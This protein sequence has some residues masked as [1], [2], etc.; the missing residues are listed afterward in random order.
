MNIM[1]QVFL[2]SPGCGAPPTA[3]AMMF[4]QLLGAKRARADSTDTVRKVFGRKGR[5]QNTFLE[6][7]DSQL[8]SQSPRNGPMRCNSAPDMEHLELSLHGQHPPDLEDED[9]TDC[10]EH[11]KDGEPRPSAASTAAPFGP[12]SAASESAPLTPVIAPDAPEEDGGGWQGRQPPLIQGERSSAPG[13]LWGSGGGYA[14]PCWGPPQD[15]RQSMPVRFPRMYGGIA[16]SPYVA[17][18]PAQQG[19]MAAMPSAAGSPTF[20]PTMPAMMMPA[21]H[22]VGSPCL[23]PAMLGGPPMSGPGSP[24]AVASPVACGAPVWTPVVAPQFEA[25]CTPLKVLDIGRC[26]E[27]LPEPRWEDE[28]CGASV[29]PAKPAVGCP[30]VQKTKGTQTAGEDGTTGGVTKA[31]IEYDTSTALRYKLLCRAGRGSPVAHIHQLFNEAFVTAGSVIRV[32]SWTKVNGAIVV[33]SAATKAELCPGERRVFQGTLAGSKVR[34]E[35]FSDWR[36]HGQD[37]ADA[38]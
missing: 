4:M 23:G 9:S 33:D 1:A 31:L 36:Q 10:P 22:P 26:W 32:D 11:D 29:L 38:E 21:A 6:V 2:L 28:T 19:P 3:C 5:V 16:L 37:Q 24:V 14:G 12:S 15:H 34:V 7:I 30:K 25:P 35:V 13:A 18:P 17:P 27:P 20:A 8:E